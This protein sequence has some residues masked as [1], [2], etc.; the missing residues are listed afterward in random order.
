[1]PGRKEGHP[2]SRYSQSGQD[3]A[4]IAASYPC[5]QPPVPPLFPAG[6]GFRWQVEEVSKH[7]AEL[8]FSTS[9]PET[10][11]TTWIGLLPLAAH[12]VTTYVSAKALA[13]KQI[14]NTVQSSSTVDTPRPTSQFFSS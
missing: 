1:M 10:L 7:A 13:N 3:C 6:S 11:G 14:R 8:P 2:A 4:A 9:P 12:P 5:S